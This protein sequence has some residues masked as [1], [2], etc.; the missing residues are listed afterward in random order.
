MPGLLLALA[1]DALIQGP[2]R[3]L[4]WRLLHDP[5]LLAAPAWLRP[6]LPAGAPF[7]RDP[8]ALLLGGGATLLATLYLAACLARAGA[9]LRA[10]L[11]ALAVALVVLLPTALHVSVGI[12]TSRPFGQDGGVVQ[13]PLALDRLLAGRSP[14]G[15]DYGDSMLG[16]QSRASS[17]W[18]EYGGN[19][20]V[21]HHAYLPGTHLAM[22]PPFALSRVAGVPFDTRCVTLVAML[23]AAFL[24][25]GLV[26]SPERKLCAAAIVTLNPLVYWH[27]AFGANDILFVALLLVSAH[28]LRRGRRV[29][30]GVVLGLACATKQ[31]A[32]PYAPFLLLQASSAGSLRDLIGR[33]ALARVRAFAV[34]A[35]IAFLIVVL[36]VIALD[37]RAFFA[38]IVAYNLGFGGDLYPFG[39][40]PGIGFANLVIVAGGVRSLRDAFPLGASLA[41]LVP[42]ALLLVRAQLRRNEIGTALAAGSVALL[43]TIY[44]SRVPHPNY[45]IAVAIL[46]PLAALSGSLRA[47]DVLLPFA[48]LALSATLVDRAPFRLL[49]EDALRS[50]STP[51]PLSSDPLGLVLAALS[52]GLALAYAAAAVLSASSLVRRSLAVAAFSLLVVA[53]ALFAARI[54]SRSHVIRA[55]EHTLAPAAAA[56]EPWSASFRLEPEGAPQRPSS[57][58]ASLVSRVLGVSDGRLVALLALAL[59]LASAVRLEASLPLASLAAVAIV[60][61]AALAAVF[62]SSVFVWLGVLCAALALAA[63][64]GLDRARAVATLAG[65][66]LLLD[67]RL[68]GSR[69][70]GPGVG[71]INVAGYAGLESTPFVHALLALGSIGVLAAAVWT[72]R[73]ATG[74]SEIWAGLALTLLLALVFSPSA[75]V[76]GLVAP[77]LLLLL[78]ASP[79]SSE[80]ARTPA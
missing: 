40:T 21:R 8:L 49:W 38:D 54:A 44:F 22:L 70:P 52:S 72:W 29:S 2:S 41:L 59:L 30:A 36:P 11:L 47:E 79:A 10:G 53:P 73:R 74:Q 63:R 3:A 43:A 31:L 20:I 13:L 42:L 12:V 45:L 37:P 5:E 27:Q 77:L 25:Q 62:G 28:R 50:G 35:L 64:G 55:V 75:S 18:R 76:F 56:R 14:H 61:S 16:K 71:L 69:D 66:L 15:G 7:D 4:A 26:E 51:I 65:P 32:W 80:T 34:S 6:W 1:G 68:G 39:G 17:F 58:A 67:Q 9:R 19:P 46:L 33:D 57:L 48:L 23:L 78:A 60:P 24:A